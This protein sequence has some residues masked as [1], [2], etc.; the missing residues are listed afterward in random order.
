MCALLISVYASRAWDCCLEFK[1]S[2]AGGSRSE[3]RFAAPHGL[4]A[5][6]GASKDET[7]SYPQGFWFGCGA[8]RGGDRQTPGHTEPPLVFLQLC[9]YVVHSGSWRPQCKISAFSVCFLAVL[10]SSYMLFTAPLCRPH[11][12]ATNYS[13][14]YVYMCRTCHNTYSVL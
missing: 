2:A 5:A 14:M 4:C 12:M 6:E 3:G 13:M 8:G 11:R 10:F 1:H 9:L 7:D